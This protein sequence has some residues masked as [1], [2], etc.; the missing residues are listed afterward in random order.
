MATPQLVLA[1]TSRYRAALLARLELPFETLAPDYDEDAAAAR[2][3]ELAP[4]ELARQLARGKAASLRAARPGAWILAADQVGVLEPPGAPKLLRKAG[5]EAAALAQLL[6]MAG[7]THEL[8]TAV[9]LASPDGSA[10]REA[11]DRQRLRMRRFDR[12]EARDYVQRHRPLDCA[13]S[14]RIE[15]AGILLFEWIESRDF[16]GIIGL[17]LLSVAR[18]LREAGLL[19]GACAT[20][21]HTAQRPR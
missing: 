3:P 6:E 18:L 1:S 12:A 11:L 2:H 17:P 7:R 16:T 4:A 20:P 10:P 14:Y 21:S 13:G 19:G 9:V 15:D 8:I 5:S